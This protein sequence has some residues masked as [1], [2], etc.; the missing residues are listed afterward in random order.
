VTNIY[1]LVHAA[2]KLTA[3]NP[4][5]ISVN[6]TKDKFLEK[7]A[8][9][10][11]TCQNIPGV[12]YKA[13]FE[14]YESIL[15]AKCKESVFGGVGLSTVERL[16]QIR[17]TPALLGKRSTQKLRRISLIG[18]QELNFYSP[19]CT[20]LLNLEYQVPV[21][22][23][24]YEDN[25]SI[26]KAKFIIDSSFFEKK[27]FS[28]TGS[29]S[30]ASRKYSLIID[31]GTRELQ[32]LNPIR[33]QLWKD[34]FLRNLDHDVSLQFNLIC[35]FYNGKRV[36]SFVEDRTLEAMM[37][38]FFPLNIPNEIKVPLKYHSKLLVKQL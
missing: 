23:E 3:V 24:F 15:N 14:V 4:T 31:L 26:F 25:N 30:S 22:R 38:S 7:V 34:D 1:D 29:W 20:G 6:A 33:A 9:L 2:F 10:C 17:R 13:L 18:E 35:G 36:P 5:L 19:R 37:L 12:S 11:Q 16:D 8:T 28:G 21:D 27:D 32:G